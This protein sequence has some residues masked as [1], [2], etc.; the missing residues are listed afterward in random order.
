MKKLTKKDIYLLFILFCLPIIFIIF[1]KLKGLVFGSNVDWISQHI[2]FPDFFRNYFYETGNLIPKF[3]LHL[4]MGQNIF[5]AFYYGYLSPVILFSYLFPFIPMSSYIQIIS[6]LSVMLSTFLIYKWINNKYNR[7]TAF[8]LALIFI[9][10]GPIIYHSCRHIMFVNYMPFLIMAIIGIDNYFENKKSNLLIISAF[11]MLLTSFYFSIPGIIVLGIYTIYKILSFEKINFLPLLKVIY[12]VLIAI[13]L[14]AF[15]ML[16]VFYVLFSGRADTSVILSLKDLFLPQLNLN[17][18][19][20]NSYSLGLTFIYIISIIHN[21]ITGKRNTLFLTIVLLLSMLIPA[22]SYVLNGLMYIDGKVFIPFLPLSLLIISNFIKDLFNK[23]VNIDVLLLISP[24]LL[25]LL[26]ISAPKSRLILLTF[27]VIITMI[28][29]YYIQKRNTPKLILIP[30]C[31]SLI[32]SFYLVNKSES[33]VKKEVLMDE[34]NYVY[35]NLLDNINE[36]TIYRTLINE[37]HLNK[38]NKVYS[39]NHYKTSIYSSIS[40]LDYI[41]FV[42]E[43]FQNEVINKDYSTVTSSS[44]VL[45]NIYSGVKYLITDKDPML[46]YNEINKKESYK[47]FE[48]SDVLPLGFA[49]NKTMSLREYE[50]L[51]YPYN[52]DALLNYVITDNEKDNVYKSSVNQCNLKGK[53]INKNNLE[54][55]KKNNK[56]Y[57]NA[58][59]DASFTYK[60]A[61]ELDNKILILK[62]LNE[63]EKEGNSCSLD[64]TINDVTNS[65]S[66]SDWKYHNKNY[67]FEYVFA[68]NNLN[69]FDVSLSE[70]EYL[71]SNLETF[72]IDYVDVAT[73]KNNVSEFIINKKLSENNIIKGKIDVKEDG[74]FKLTIPYEKKGFSVFV[75]GKKV[76]YEK[77]DKTFIGFPIKKGIQEIK[78]IYNPP[79]LKQGIYIT[80]I[81]I[82]LFVFNFL[83][84]AKNKHIKKI[85]E[86]TKD[87]FI[88]SFNKI[89]SFI[90]LNKSYIFMFTSLYI[91]DL[92]IRIYHQ[93]FISF[94]KWYYLVPNIFS[95]LIIL[96]ILFITNLFKNKAIYLA[97][98]ILFIL[99]FIAQS[100]YFSYFSTF[101]DFTILK[102]AEEG[103]FYLVTILLN[104]NIWILITAIVSILLMVLGLKNI[105]YKTYE[106]TTNILIVII[107]ILLYAVIP[108]FLGK[109]K[110]EIAWDDWRNPRAIYDS[111]N[112]NN[113]SFNV[114]GLFQ[115]TIRDIYI[116]FI[117]DNESLTEKEKLILKDNFENNNLNKSNKY[118]G[119]FEDKNLILIQL[120][121]V[122]N[123]L[124]TKKLMPVTYDLMKNSINFT[125]HFSFTS[126]GGSTFNSE[127]MVNTG[128]STAYDYHMNAYAFSR[129]NYEYSLANLLKKHNYEPFVFHMNSGEYYSRRTNYKSFGYDEYY[130]LKEQDQY[131]DNN[132][133]ILDR[134]L[135]LNNKFNKHLF[136]A[137]DLFLNYIIT[138]S[139]HMPFTPLRGVCEKLTDDLN[140]TE[141][142][143]LNLQAKETDYFMKLLLEDLEKKEKI[144]DTVIAVFTD[145]YLYTLEEKDYLNKYKTTDNNLINH[146]PFFIW[147]NNEVKKTIKKVNSQLDILPTILNLMGI[148][149]YPS[150]YLGRDILAD[151]FKEIAYFNDGSWY[152]GKT[153]V[154]DGEYLFGN[155]KSEDK[156]NEINTFVK[157]KMLL[158][159]AVLKSNYFSTFK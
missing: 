159:D 53:I 88:K 18:T 48:N 20:Y 151:D 89:K 79:L 96:L 70:G 37:N 22:V 8:I 116:T 114:S 106:N 34:N 102:L 75:D 84:E 26:F 43:E 157:N 92:T 71:L 147:S 40:N 120:E 110:D 144:D 1:L 29:L 121:G 95:I 45:F 39:K 11:L 13:F 50:S 36:N 58:K 91:L 17:L 62:F 81:G 19:F 103:T 99:S 47:L 27:D 93:N 12:S 87:L 16:P 118:T 14:S 82:I 49:T 4:G 69:F 117:K 123:F 32:A 130:G 25:I 2:V 113:K 104:I 38:V 33:F 76:N 158:N 133:Y 134:E 52:I 61:E 35:K 146:T 108:L 128:Y 23:K 142:D 83:L 90:Y 72:I 111:F 74:Y 77:V 21:L 153:Y 155:K 119:L 107:F 98:Y 139:V 132:D 5:Y 122:E 152:D 143:C 44:N 68:N 56:Y 100:L 64:I 127:F 129:N 65:L 63:K 9:L 41:N 85:R 78:I 54:I 86:K 42:R 28:F 156:I 60:L 126:G 24:L 141:A 101:Y 125:N 55:I 66:C 94:Y 97:F 109:T 124:I 138:Y 145:H 136:T 57:I 46:G 150:H 3:N 31:L 10:S 149:Y 135:I 7:N 154:K 15:V 148:S 105:Y 112:D 115:Y 51:K 80:F 67:T 6:V 137:N 73:I 140:L 131:K 59:E 30:I